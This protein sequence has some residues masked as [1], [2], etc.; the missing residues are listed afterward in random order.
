MC[1][2]KKWRVEIY[3]PE[4]EECVEIGSDFDDQNQAWTAAHEAT[5]HLL[6]A[7][8]FKTKDRTLHPIIYI[9]KPNGSRF[10]YMDDDDE[11]L[12]QYA[13]IAKKAT[14][15]FEDETPDI[16]HYCD[17]ENNNPSESE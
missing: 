4:D 9:I 13:D 14:Q 8:L 17:D 15:D 1:N 10:T 11:L 16:I 3:Y 5:S 7:G 12:S 2:E 6:D